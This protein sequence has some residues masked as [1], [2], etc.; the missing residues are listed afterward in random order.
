VHF[1]GLTVAFVLLTAVLLVPA[2]ASAKKPVKGGG[3]G[4]GS[5]GFST[6]ST[7]VKN[8][9]N[10]VNGVQYDL[11]PLDV[12]ATPD[13]G[14]ITLATT[15][16]PSPSGVGT[17]PGLSW[18]LKTSAVGAPQWEEEVGC[19]STPPGAYSDALS[20]QLT[21]DGGYVLAGGTIG[22][23]SGT[24]CPFLSGL[25]CGLVER[26]DSAGRLEWARVY[27]SGTTGAEFDS[28]VPTSD[29][30]FVAAGSTSDANHNLGGFIVKL[31]GAGNVQ[32]QRTL[33]PTGTDQVY[34]H[35]VAQT[36]DG[37]FI[38]VG[39]LHDGTTTS[40][41]AQ[42]ESALAVKLDAAGNVSWLHAY[43]D[44]GSGGTVTAAIHAFTVVQ[45]AGGGYAVGGNWGQEPLLGECCS[46]GLLLQLT[47][48]GSIRS[49][50]AYSGGLYCF[51]NGYSE[52]CTSI[53]SV[54]NSLHQTADGG[55]VLAG[56]A[57]LKLL[58]EASI[59]PWLAK[60]DGSGA[61]VWQEQDYQVNSSSGRPLSEDFASSALTAAGPLAVGSTENY[62]NGLGEVLGVQTDGNGAVASCSQIHPASQ[63]SPVDPG[64]SEITPNITVTSPLVSQSPAASQTL[65]TT[66]TAT[67][68]QC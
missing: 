48:D 64:L 9:A 54:I 35:D 16:A 50:T 46:G 10:V 28:I 60:V 18:L 65:A 68:A 62:S 44:V 4:S 56:D 37:G 63:L 34:L 36:S 20:L 39:Q 32:W 7:Y 47:P 6:T 17:G 23:G 26:L 45:T 8:Y 12:K 43:N 59:A 52:T 19:P 58:D 27:S 31:D 40:Y 53:G 41:G 33:G 55:F 66:A 29:G 30:G 24:D 1:R 11:T 38:A 51:D 21:S 13:G 3:G 15:F 25:Q 57:N 14:A 2:A 5:G 61:P 42:L 49:Q 67:A 22:C